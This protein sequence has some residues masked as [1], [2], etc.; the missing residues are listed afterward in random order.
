MN[1]TLFVLIMEDDGEALRQYER[2]FPKDYDGWEIVYD[3][4]EDFDEAMKRLS[5][6]RYDMV[7]T[8]VYLNR[9]D[10]QKGVNPSDNKA[11]EIIKSIRESHA[12]PI[13]VTTDGPKPSDLELS[14]FVIYARKPTPGELEAEVKTLLATGIPIAARALHDELERQANS[15]LWGFLQQN[16]GKLNSDGVMSGQAIERLMRRR[17]AVQ[18]GKIDKV[19]DEIGEVLVV[20]AN[21]FYLYPPLSKK[22]YRLGQIIQHKESHELR[23]I[24]TPH[25]HLTI[26][27]SQTQPR[28]DFILTSRIDDHDKVLFQLYPHP[29]KAYKGN[30]SDQHKEKLRRRIQSPADLG[31]PD[32]RYWFLPKFLDVP[33]SYCDLMQLQSLS[34]SEI[35]E[36]YESLAVLDS[37]FAEAL[38]SCFSRLYSAVGLPKLN[39]E[40]FLHLIKN[41]EPPQS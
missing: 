30:D 32:G 40:K 28:A 9:T 20:E 38:Q 39:V 5:S 24:L 11:T 35:A 4:C 21:E 31:S 13:V 6:R 12:C 34:I 19:G 36:N 17:A 22:E 37:P 10:R 18:F 23:I 25:C 1:Q 7:I 15:Y 29:A 16:W 27:D 2:S 8:D 33:D 14:P 3:P 41:A 26:Q